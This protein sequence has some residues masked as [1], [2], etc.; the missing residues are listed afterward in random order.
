MTR[1]AGKLLRV[2]LL[3]DVLA[4]AQQVQVVI[5][6]T[7]INKRVGT[8]LRISLNF[9]CRK[10]LTKS[11][12]EIKTGKTL[13][14]TQCEQRLMASKKGKAG[15]TIWLGFF[16]DKTTIGD[17]NGIQW[18]PHV[19]ISRKDL[20]K[21]QLVLLFFTAKWLKSTWASCLLAVSYCSKCSGGW[22]RNEL[23]SG[24][25]WAH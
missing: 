13:R 3:Q 8:Y 2:L 6:E 4:E 9:T 15:F 11:F 5:A 23:G 17:K 25:I 21:V 16:E 1:L 22:R 19:Q 24:G 12:S 20:T 10:C 14:N 7:W 18:T